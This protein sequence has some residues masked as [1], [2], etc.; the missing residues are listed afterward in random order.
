MGDNVKYHVSGEGTIVFKRK[1]GTPL[2]MIDVKYV[3]GPKKNLV[4]IAMLEDKGYDV[5][6]NK[7]NAFLR[8]ISTG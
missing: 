5:D 8:H 3:S 2:T 1:H 6:F 4:F 7:G